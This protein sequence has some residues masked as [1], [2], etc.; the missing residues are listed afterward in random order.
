MYS[1]EMQQK[2]KIK[3]SFGFSDY[4]IWIGCFQFCLLWPEYLSSAVNVLRNSPGISDITKR[5]VFQL[6][7][8]QSDETIV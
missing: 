7:F 1:P 8:S 4:C 5:D 2:K 6:N 3:K